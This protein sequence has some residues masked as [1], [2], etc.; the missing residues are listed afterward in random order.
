MPKRTKT[1]KIDLTQP[2]YEEDGKPS[3]YK[4]YR[5]EVED[6][7]DVKKDL[8]YKQLT[9]K[10]IIRYAVAATT[11]HITPDEIETKW[12]IIKKVYEGDDVELTEKE[13]KLARE[14]IVETRSVIHAGQA[15]KFLK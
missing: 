5:W 11:T 1:F 8:G 3:K 9:L 15:L 13:L 4:L 14:C 10:E 7:E 2:I 12:D 6:G